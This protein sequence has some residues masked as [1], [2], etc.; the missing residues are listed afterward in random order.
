MGQSSQNNRGALEVNRG[1]KKKLLLLPRYDAQG[2][3]SRLR[4]YQ[5][6]PYLAESWEV[7]VAP[8]FR[9]T[10]LQSLYKGRRDA[11][12]VSRSFAN[13]IRVLRRHARFDLL[14][15]ESELFPWLPWSVE[16]ALARVRVPYVVDYD[17]AVF[18]RYDQHC[19]PIVRRLLGT[20]IASVMTQARV[21]MVG[22]KYIAAYARAAGARDV[23]ALP[24][25]VDLARYEAKAEAGTNALTIG[26]I[27]T[28]ITQ[29]YLRV[30]ASG[31]QFAQRRLGARIVAIG[32]VG[33]PVADVRVEIRPWE[34]DTEV[35]E[36]R[37]LTIGVMPLVDSA[38]ERGK[39]GYKLIQYMATGIPVVASPVGVNAEIVDH[40]VTGF[41]ASTEE[42]WIHYLKILAESPD[43]RARMGAAGRRKVRAQYCAEVVAP[44]LLDVLGS[45]VRSEEG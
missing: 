8:F 38:W 11:R 16:C 13:R 41:L 1:R 24:T 30:A 9:A 18:H 22:N 12:E 3:S 6:L 2:A 39:C 5:Y 15:I 34:L 23:A 35:E 20:K 32:A 42:D 33:E 27:G 21:V 14:W 31:L 4:A 36:L 43:L 45:A 44:R 28:P 25:A 10:Y 26:W 37:R 7:S 29:Q 40:G 17:D 19:S